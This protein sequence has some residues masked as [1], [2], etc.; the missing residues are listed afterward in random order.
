MGASNA[1]QILAALGL[2]HSALPSDPFAFSTAFLN[3]LAP[4]LAPVITTLKEYPMP[5]LTLT[6]T[7]AVIASDL[8][9]LVAFKFG[10]SKQ[11]GIVYGLRFGLPKN[12]KAAQDFPGTRYKV[13]TESNTGQQYIYR[14]VPLTQIRAFLTSTGSNAVM[15]DRALGV[16]AD[17]T[18]DAVVP[19]WKAG[20]RVSDGDRTGIITTDDDVVWLDDGFVGGYTAEDITTALQA[21]FL[22]LVS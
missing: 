12:S 11:N 16:F 21:D 8:N 3:G 13:V 14:Y 2:L 1:H 6:K 15:L 17:V 18:Q 20:D 22:Q 19:T 10:D 5:D 9:V 7:V 4:I